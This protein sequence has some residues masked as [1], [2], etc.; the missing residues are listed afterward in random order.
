MTLSADP[1]AWRLLKCGV[2]PLLRPLLFRHRS[3]LPKSIAELG[4]DDTHLAT[5]RSPSF[6]LSSGEHAKAR[7][8]DKCLEATADGE[9]CT[10]HEFPLQSAGT[11]RT[12]MDKQGQRNYPAN[13]RVAGKSPGSAE[14]QLGILLRPAPSRGSVFP[15]RVGV[16]CPIMRVPV[17]DTDQAEVILESLGSG[18]VENRR[19]N[20]AHQVR[21]VF[22]PDAFERL[23]ETLDAQILV[24]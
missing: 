4:L 2:R 9:G 11:M 23:D 18:K 6:S 21:E 10:V 15:G 19:C 5:V 12:P 8:P 13:L 17:F 14:S 20:A 16:S 24:A 22:G 1:V 7:T 3:P